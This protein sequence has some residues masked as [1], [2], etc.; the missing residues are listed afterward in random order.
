ADFDFHL[1]ILEATK[2]PILA[3]IAKPIVILLRNSRERLLG[4]VGVPEISFRQHQ[5]IYNAIKKGDEK[6]ASRAM[7]RHLKQVE[8]DVKRMADIH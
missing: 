5:D 7:L 3:A 6:E 4:I 8:E 2:N 1:T